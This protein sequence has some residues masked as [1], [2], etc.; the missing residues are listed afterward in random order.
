[1]KVNEKSSG[2]NNKMDLQ[3]DKRES[4]FQEVVKEEGEEIKEEIHVRES[5]EA[6][7][8]KCGQVKYAYNAFDN[9]LMVDVGAWRFFHNMQEE[10][11]KFNPAAF[12]GIIL[13]NMTSFLSKEIHC[14]NSFGVRITPSVMDDKYFG[15]CG[16]KN[17]E[18]RLVKRKY[19]RS[20]GWKFRK[21][22]PPKVKRNLKSALALRGMAQFDSM[23]NFFPYTTFYN[24]SFK[25][26]IRV[27]QILSM[28]LVLSII[29]WNVQQKFGALNWLEH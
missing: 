27:F 17:E 2:I 24:F 23:V 9:M 3:Q 16:D 21:I 28:V 8:S 29:V 14:H 10:K 11:T 25:E 20:R 22:N 5:L 1:M 12:E 18:I 7:D 19:C 13:V 4:E 6:M 26:N 15:I